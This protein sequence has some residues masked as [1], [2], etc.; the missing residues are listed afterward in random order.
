MCSDREGSLPI[1][2]GEDGGP[3]SEGGVG[4]HPLSHSEEEEG[5]R[6]SAQEPGLAW[7]GRPAQ[8]MGWEEHGSPPRAKALLPNQGQWGLP[9]AQDTGRGISGAQ[10][11]GCGGVVVCGALSGRRRSWGWG[12]SSNRASS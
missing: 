7:P 11:R 8:D 4:G 6:S 10:G 1:R 9:E 5:P 12:V 2:R 3:H